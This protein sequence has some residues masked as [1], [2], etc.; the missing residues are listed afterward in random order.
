[1]SRDKTLRA[2]LA[3]RAEVAGSEKRA[4]VGLAHDGR[5]VLVH[6]DDPRRI[7]H[8]ICRGVG[9]ANETF[10]NLKLLSSNET[11]VVLY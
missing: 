7:R 11:F 5:V 9:S 6:A 2:C 3:A 10:V 1:M 4:R 8:L